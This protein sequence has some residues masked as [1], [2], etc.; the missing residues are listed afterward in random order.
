MKK[1]NTPTDGNAKRLSRT[2]KLQ[3]S[4]RVKS[5]SGKA[6]NNNE[7]PHKASLCVCPLNPTPKK[8]KV[9]LQM[10]AGSSPTAKT[11]AKFIWR[12]WGLLKFLEHAKGGTWVAD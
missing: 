7:H 2:Q 3:A 12:P 10:Q 5:G 1:M 4:S 9:E 6:R 11:R 8:Q